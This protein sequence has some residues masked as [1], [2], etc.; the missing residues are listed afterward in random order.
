MLRHVVTTPAGSKNARGSSGAGRH[1]LS[2]VGLQSATSGRVL[3]DGPI[4]LG[5][6]ARF[7]THWRVVFGGLSVRRDHGR[8]HRYAKPH[9]SATLIVD[10]ARRAATSSYGRSRTDTNSDWRARRALSGDSGKRVACPSDPCGPKISIL[11]EGS[12]V[13]QRERGTAPGSCKSE[14]SRPCVVIAT[15]IAM[16]SDDRSSCLKRGILEHDP[17]ECSRKGRYYQLYEGQYQSKGIGSGP[18]RRTIGRRCAAQGCSAERRM[19]LSGGELEGSV[20]RAPRIPQSGRGPLVVEDEVEAMASRASRELEGSATDAVRGGGPSGEAGSRALF[21]RSLHA[22]AMIC[23]RRVHARRSG[24]IVACA[25]RV[26]S[27]QAPSRPRSNKGVSLH[28]VRQRDS[29]TVRR[30]TPWHA[31]KSRGRPFSRPARWNPKPVFADERTIAGVTLPS[32]RWTRVG[33]RNI[34]VVSLA[35]TRMTGS[36]L[37][38]LGG[39][40][41]LR[42]ARLPGS[43]AT[44]LLSS[45]VGRRRPI[46]RGPRRCT[47]NGPPSTKNLLVPVRF[48]ASRFRRIS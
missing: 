40:L 26:C 28:R 24:P 44:P 2:L 29:K 23:G 11:D 21:A 18:R 10:A 13:R 15:T 32:K 4:S 35:R 7:Q 20:R 47:R 8:Q 36:F 45:R 16:Q 33:G 43:L 25:P 34:A 9:A 37:D 48:L 27:S 39:P 5:A 6:R 30:D 42:P 3:V 17:S 1:D 14:T 41:G 38:G 12:Q 22:H 19:T 46:R 31:S